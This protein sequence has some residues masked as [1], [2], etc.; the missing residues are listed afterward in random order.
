MGTSHFIHFPLFIVMVYRLNMYAIKKDPTKI[1]LEV[2]I[3]KHQ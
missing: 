1:H 3:R 2:H